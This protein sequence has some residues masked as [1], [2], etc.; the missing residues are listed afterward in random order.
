MVYFDDIWFQYYWLDVPQSF[1]F[2][3]NCFQE[4]VMWINVN[5]EIIQIILYVIFEIDYYGNYINETCLICTN[6]CP[7]NLLLIA[8]YIYILWFILITFDFNIIGYTFINHLFFSGTVF[9]S[10]YI[11]PTMNLLNIWL[12]C[13]HHCSRIVSAYMVWRDWSPQ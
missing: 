10:W 7:F 11:N 3:R 2:F 13:T 6:I 12:F 8:G 5:Y 1:I 4:L 9:K